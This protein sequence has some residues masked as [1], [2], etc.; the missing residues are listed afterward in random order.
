MISALQTQ[1]KGWPSPQWRLC[2]Y[3]LSPALSYSLISYSSSSSSPSSTTTTTSA[4][5]SGVATSAGSSGVAENSSKLNSK[6]SDA[7]DDESCRLLYQFL[8]TFSNTNLTEA[9]CLS[10]HSLKGQ[11]GDGGLHVTFQLSIPSYATMSDLVDIVRKFK[12]VMSYSSSS[13]MSNSNVKRTTRYVDEENWC[14]TGL[15]AFD[16]SLVNH[17]KVDYD[18]QTNSIGGD[19]DVAESRTCVVK[20][21]LPYGYATK[22]QFSQEGSK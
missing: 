5:S 18:L 12:L 15:V 21:H 13:T 14:G 19:D 22:L 1:S 10:N 17:S 6:N 20:L 3:I 16:Y 11:E 8:D 2:Q 4:G 9:L 7:A